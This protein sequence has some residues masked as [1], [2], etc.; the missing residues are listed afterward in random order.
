MGMNLNFQPIF[1]IG[2]LS[3]IL[4]GQFGQ[5]AWMNPGFG[6]QIQM[7]NATDLSTEC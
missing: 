4:M 6:N 5:Q 7:Q 1:R 3:M 2:A